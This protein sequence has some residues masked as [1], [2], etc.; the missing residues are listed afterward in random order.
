MSI[1]LAS[2]IVAVIG[3]CSPSKP[4]APINRKLPAFAAELGKAK[5]SCESRA[6]QAKQ[7]P[8]IRPRKRRD[9]QTGERLYGN[10]KSEL[11]SVIAFLQTSLVT[12]FEG[13]SNR[14][15]Q[16][17]MEQA[18]SKM[19]DFIDWTDD[20]YHSP[21]QAGDEVTAAAPSADLFVEC[22]RLVGE[23]VMYVRNED[24]KR[25]QQIRADL[26]KH[27]LKSWAEL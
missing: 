10:A 22:V 17:R 1:V 20:R 3:G 15:V 18:T 25:I 24:E 8:A 14:D 13:I 12:R 5:S 21:G 27:K 2:L 7:Q 9:L 11:D 19:S 16:T 26:E 4:P 6:Q 23:W